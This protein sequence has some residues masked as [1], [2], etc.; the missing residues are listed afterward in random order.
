MNNPKVAGA[1]IIYSWK[2]L[3]PKKDIYNLKPI[4]E[5]LSFLSKH[6]KKL[7][8]QIQ[9]RSFSIDNIPVPNY[10]L[11]DKYD[12]GVSKQIDFAGEG[13]ATGY[14]WVAKQWNPKVQKRFQKLLTYL[15]NELDGKIAGINLPETSID[16]ENINEKNKA[17][18]DKYFNAVL[19]NMDVLKKAFKHSFAVQYVNFFPGEWNNDQKYMQRLFEYAV[20]YKIGLGNPDTVPFRKGQMKNSYQFFNKYKE[21]LSLIAIAVQEPDYTYTNP[22]TKKKFTVKELYDFDRDYIGADI[23]FWNIQEPEFTE[24]VIPFLEKIIK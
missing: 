3:E 8:I 19:N 1:Q 16:V 20:K 9:D 4:F 5:D 12:S 15:G 21:K 7:F 14:G 6:N 17:N 10:L 13:Q 22:K 24:K 23:I 2:R 11:T 18:C